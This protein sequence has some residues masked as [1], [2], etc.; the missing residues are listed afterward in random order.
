MGSAP[1]TARPKAG[2]SRHRVVEVAGVS[3][4][5]RVG[6]AEA[7]GHPP[8]AGVVAA[9]SGYQAEEARPAAA[10]RLGAARAL[11]AQAARKGSVDPADQGLGSLHFSL[12]LLIH[13]KY[14][15]GRGKFRSCRSKEN[16]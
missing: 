5:L 4:L 9:G 10:R 11:V 3:A 8:A 15:L 13:K 2:C 6:A 16:R 7:S 1:R 14:P 12:L